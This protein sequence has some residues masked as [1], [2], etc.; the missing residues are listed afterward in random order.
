M[1]RLAAGTCPHLDQD[2]VHPTASRRPETR[3]RAEQLLTRCVTTSSRPDALGRVTWR[4]V[5]LLPSLSFNYSLIIFLRRKL[6]FRK[7]LCLNTGCAFLCNRVND[8]FDSSHPHL[9]LLGPDLSGGGHRQSVNLGFFCMFVLFEFSC[10]S[11]S[12]Q[13]PG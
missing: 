6:H 8:C 9:A 13:C 10:V 5:A 2:R 3:G 12:W 1:E 11:L 4:V 7:H